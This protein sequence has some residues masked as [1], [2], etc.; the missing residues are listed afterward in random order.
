MPKSSKPTTLRESTAHHFRTAKQ[1]VHARRSAFLKRRPHRS[2]QL[3]RRRDYARSLELPGYWKFTRQV[4]QLLWKHK[5]T[6]LLLAGVYALL[7]AAFIGLGSQST[8]TELVATLRETSSD[9]FEGQ[10]GQIQQAGL[11]FA[12]LATSGLSGTLTGEQQIYS[13]LFAL[14]VWLTVIWLLRQFMADRKV[15]LRDGLYSAGAPLIPT[16]L[17]TLVMAVQ[18]FPLAIAGIAYASAQSSG[19]LNGGVEAMLFWSAAVLATVLSLY[20]TTATFFATVIVTLPGTYPLAALQT[21][22]D[23]V[24]GR[25]VRLLLRLLWMIITVAAFWAVVLIPIILIDGLVKGWWP[26]IEWF[27][28]V[29]IVLLV[30]GVLSMIWSAAYVYVLYRKVIEDDSAPA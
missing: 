24:V 10:W 25:R 17:L 15:K 16:F 1:R 30:L 5:N 23:M 9:V 19:L 21:A 8:Y 2:F 22:G 4:W 13:I 26:A 11:L 3:T 6:F 14:L 28:L 27:P 12:S 7:S 18:L 29:P 20:W